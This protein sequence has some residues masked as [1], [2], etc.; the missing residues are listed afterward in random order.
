MHILGLRCQAVRD[1]LAPLRDLQEEGDGADRRLILMQ[2]RRLER[3]TRI[4][5][6]RWLAVRKSWRDFPCKIRTGSV[7]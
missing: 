7:G 2:A 4:F 1:A 5:S 6:S 3:S